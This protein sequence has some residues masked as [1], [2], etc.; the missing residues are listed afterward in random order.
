MWINTSASF[1]AASRIET[2]C[3]TRAIL[4]AA[5]SPP[6]PAPRRNQT[7]DRLQICHTNDQYV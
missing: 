6:R 2:L 3:P 4:I 5:A 1:R 7:L